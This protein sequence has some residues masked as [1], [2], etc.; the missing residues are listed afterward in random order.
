MNCKRNWCLGSFP[1][2]TVETAG[3]R[4]AGR[5]WLPEEPGSRVP[6]WGWGWLPR[7]IPGEVWCQPRAPRGPPSCYLSLLEVCEAFRDRC[8]RYVVSATREGWVLGLQLD[9]RELLGH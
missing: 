7:E 3:V 1:V 4:V 6:L 2:R 9:V 8:L 5:L